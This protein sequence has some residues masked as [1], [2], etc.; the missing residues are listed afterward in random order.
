MSRKAI[1]IGGGIGGLTVATALRRA[2]VD[3]V[4]F[5]RR[6]DLR[7]LTAG[8]GMVL[9]HN[10][11][12]ALQEL[13]LWERVEPF[14]TPLEQATWQTWQGKEL[15][16]WK[17]GEMGRRL[18][19]PA[20]GIRRANLLSA[21]AAALPDSVLRLGAECTSFSHDASGVKAMFAD[22]SEEMGDVLI[23][24]DGINSAV[25][26]QQLGAAKPRY[27]GYALWFGIVEA[28]RVE[29]PAATFR[30]VAGP[31]ARF[32]LFPVGESSYYWSAVINRAEGGHD[33]ETGAKAE[34]L[35]TYRGWPH[36]VEALLEATDEATIYRRDIVDRDPVTTWGEGRVT[37]LG[38]AA[39]PITPNLG[40][41]AAQAIEDAVIIAK[42]LDTADGVA[43][44]LRAYE[45][46]RMSRTASFTKRARQIG[47]MGR[48]TNPIAC[49]FRHVVMR[50]V[51]PTVAWR[52]HQKDMAYKF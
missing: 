48:W 21:L 10:A 41:G 6:N 2:G 4:V 31:G 8:A 33:P 51:F 35:A 43:S 38:D 24:A 32:F 11:V 26:T 29:V 47:E 49:G 23:G 18:Q 5:E 25:R 28:D 50:I 15:A 40:Q 42:C 22:G 34:L 20:V 13:E 37:L 27:A 17:V 39:H 44:A 12:R 7:D 14:G 36:P 30:E 9:W 19:A 46:R 16:L 45:E 3:V 52:Q 1:V